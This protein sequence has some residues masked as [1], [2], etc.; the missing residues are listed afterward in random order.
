MKASEGEVMCY[1]REGVACMWF[2]LE[3]FLQKNA[4]ILL[5]R[6]IGTQ[7]LLHIRE[8]IHRNRIH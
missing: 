4:K 2:F 5:T 8:I 7:C 3:I 1:T 6:I